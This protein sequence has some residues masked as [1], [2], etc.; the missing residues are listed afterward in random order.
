MSWSLACAPSE[1]SVTAAAPDCC[2][3]SRSALR[4]ARA[5]S[6]V[7]PRVSVRT[8]AA[9]AGSSSMTPSA[10]SIVTPSARR[11]SCSSRA[12]ARLVELLER[13][14]LV[15]VDDLDG[16]RVTGEDDHPQV[17]AGGDRV[18]GR[19]HRRRARVA[20]QRLVL[21]RAGRVDGDDGAHRAVG[22]RVHAA[23]RVAG[24]GGAR[25]VAAA[26]AAERDQRGCAEP[27][28]GV[29]RDVIC[30]LRPL[31]RL[32]PEMVDTR[33]ARQSRFA[34]EVGTLVPP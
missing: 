10:L 25:G 8:R 7:P 11:R 20:R 3:A 12:A 24:L 5:M 2:L 15:V 33:H 28:S 9:S 14:H 1:T 4:T 6:D 19:P 13:R 17:P 31:D 27:A 32:D 26:T 34:A 16:V 18:L 30:A 22:G 29:H 21:Q 23:G